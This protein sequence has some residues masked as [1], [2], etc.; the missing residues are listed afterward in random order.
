MAVVCAAAIWCSPHDLARHRDRSEQGTTHPYAPAAPNGAS[1]G[2]YR[3]L[4]GL[5]PREAR[6]GP[7]GRAGEHYIFLEAVKSSRIVD[8]DLAPKAR[9]GNASRKQIEEMTG[10]DREVRRKIR[11]TSTGY[12]GRVDVWPT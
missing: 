9:V 11:L 5:A 8:Q 6:K 1:T 2:F 3:E 10:I 7:F 4:R 12:R